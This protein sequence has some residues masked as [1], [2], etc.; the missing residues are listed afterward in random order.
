MISNHLNVVLLAGDTAAA[1]FEW[2]DKRLWECLAVC[3]EGVSQR[4][5]PVVNEAK[6]F[7]P[8]ERD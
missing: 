3:T 4:E 7:K 5:M 6:G 1:R 8:K 2:S